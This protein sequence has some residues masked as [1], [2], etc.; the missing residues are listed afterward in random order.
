MGWSRLVEAY[1][2]KE[3]VSKK[4]G[5]KNPNGNIILWIHGGITITMIKMFITIF[6]KI[7]K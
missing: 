2:R 5:K 6:H 1:H 4:M 3:L 7:K